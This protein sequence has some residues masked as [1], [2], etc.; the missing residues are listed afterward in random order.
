MYGVVKTAILLLSSLLVTFKFNAPNASWFVCVSICLIV[1]VSVPLPGE[2]NKIVYLMCLPGVFSGHCQVPA[3]AWSMTIKNIKIIVLVINI[4]T[5]AH[6]S[7]CHV[8]ILRHF[9]S[10]FAQ[11]ERIKN[12]LNFFSEIL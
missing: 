6:P 1:M 8:K 10:G 4:T 9:T 11:N 12:G 7:I 3:R 5:V 2:S